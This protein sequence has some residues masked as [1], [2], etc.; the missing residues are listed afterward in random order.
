M[1]TTCAGSDALW[2]GLPVLTCTGRSFPSR[3]GASLLQALGLP[4]LITGDLGSYEA[5]ALRLATEPGLL[6]GLRAQLARQLPTA[7]LYD[8]ARYTRDLEAAYTVMVERAR[9]GLAPAGFA[10]AG[11]GG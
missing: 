3:V 8:T 7:P 2:A 6:A 11:D 5:L 1:T 10:V 4:E 9:D